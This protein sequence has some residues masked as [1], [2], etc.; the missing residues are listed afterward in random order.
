MITAAHCINGVDL[1]QKGYVL[2]AV[3]LGENDLRTDPDCD[4]VKFKFTFDCDHFIL[5]FIR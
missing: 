5:H 2:D 4:E 3:R 1:V